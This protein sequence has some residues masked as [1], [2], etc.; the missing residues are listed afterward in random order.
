MDFAPAKSHGRWIGLA[1]V[2]AAMAIEIALWAAA[3]RAG[4]GPVAALLGLLALLGLPLVGLI[5]YQAWG[6]INLRYNVSRDGVVIRWAAA[7]QIVP[8]AEITHI[9]AGRPYAAPLRGLCWSGSACGR[10][11][12]GDDQ[13]VVRPAL[14]YATTP[15]EGQLIL[16]TRSLA[17][18]ISPADRAAFIDDFKARR[19]LGPAQ[20]LQQATEQ[21]P[22]ARLSLWRDPLALGLLVGAVLLSGLVFALITWQYPALPTEVMLQWRYEPAI[23]ATVP[24]PP[25]PLGEIWRL[26]A[27]GLAA[28]LV[29]GVAAAA[30]HHRA[31]LGAVLLL[32]GAVAVQL[33]LFLVLARAV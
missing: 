9:L 8:M 17:Y 16:V 3:R 24:G 11:M 15:P 20:N 14:V 1:L 18:A 5:A 28:V 4:L 6:S 12:I 29:N 30:V 32:G 25:L 23:G 7:R 31:R 22:W 26:P 27:I 21:A 10:T 13:G 19:R 2:A 33:A